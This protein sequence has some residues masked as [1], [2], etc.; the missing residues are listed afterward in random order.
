[1]FRRCSSCLERLHF[2]EASG[3]WIHYRLTDVRH[4]RPDGSCGSWMPTWRWSLDGLR[5]KWCDTCDSGA[6]YFYESDD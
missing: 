2:E 3:T 4:Y 6:Y 5:A 1:M